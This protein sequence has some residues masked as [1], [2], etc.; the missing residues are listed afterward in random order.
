MVSATYLEE[1]GHLRPATTFY[2]SIHRIPCLC[3]YACMFN[4]LLL[5]R[6]QGFL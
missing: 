2:G 6:V 5:S 3:P 1:G 4:R